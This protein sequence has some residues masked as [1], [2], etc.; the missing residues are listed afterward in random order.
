[1]S[2]PKLSRYFGVRVKGTKAQPAYGLTF[3]LNTSEERPHDLVM[4]AGAGKQKLYIIPSQRLLIVQFAE[5][6]RRFQEREL[7]RLVLDGVSRS[8]AHT[9][10]P[11]SR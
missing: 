11:I 1:M 9:L 2:S 10:R 6:T 3:W 5:A 4:A 8:E 7:M